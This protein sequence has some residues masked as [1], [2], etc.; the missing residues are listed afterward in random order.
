MRPRRWVAVAAA[1]AAAGPAAVRA[2]QLEP[3]GYAQDV[4]LGNVANG[5]ARSGLTEA[6]RLRLMLG[7]SDGPLHLDLA[8][9]QFLQWQSRAGAAAFGALPAVSAP[10]DWLPL[11][12]TLHRW[13]RGNWHHRMDRLSLAWTR[14]P[15]ALTVGRQAISWATTLFL[16]PADPF[17][18]FN[19]SDPFREFRTGVDAARVQWY[20]GPFTEL[21]VVGRLADVPGGTDH[22]LLARGRTT[23]HG[24]DLAAWG[25]TLDD[26]A[27]GAVGVTRTL[28]GAA[29]RG[30][31]ELRRRGG[32]AVLRASVGADRRFPVLGRDLYVVVEYQHDGLGAADAVTLPATV[33]SREAARGELQVYGR[34]EAMGQVTWQV[35]PLVSLE[36]LTLW[37]LADHSALLAPAVSVSVTGSMTAR[38]GLFA[39]TGRE[40][41]GLLPGSEYG[42]LPLLGYGAVS[43]FF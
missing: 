42:T 16:S 19:P 33:A 23:L 27:A 34:D 35:H 18:P 31:A 37:N 10:G 41:R 13:D 21:E 20:V 3:A 2:Q 36:W 7:A 17:V 24:W 14:G 40:Q 43:L 4:L 26:A 38:A 28:A 29:L 15:V 12:G 30:E 6:A 32:T 9:E 11:D 25:G 39:A 8:Y 1:L 5:F 22:T